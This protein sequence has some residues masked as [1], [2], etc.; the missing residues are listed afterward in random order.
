MKEFKERLERYTG[1]YERNIKKKE[2]KKTNHFA[3]AGI[4][5]AVITV[6][7][8][9]V[10]SMLIGMSD[11]LSRNFSTSIKIFIRNFTGIIPVIIILLPVT[12]LIL[13][14]IGSRKAKHDNTIEPASNAIGCN[15]LAMVGAFFLGVVFVTGSLGIRPN[16]HLAECESNIKNMA[17]ALEM[18]AVENN[19]HYPSDLSYLIKNKRDKKYM[20][21]IPECP[22]GF[23]GYDYICSTSPDNFTIWCKNK[24]AH[25]KL[26]HEEGSW[27]QYNPGQGLI[28]PP[29]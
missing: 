9:Y 1:I 6:F 12:G 20:D 27:P 14:I 13:S 21:K 10:I 19:N 15:V 22:A 8:P 24:N 4:A 11:E 26:L 3:M 16:R 28:L 5:L 18:Y 2:R 25:K 29:R 23:T 7:S 17:V